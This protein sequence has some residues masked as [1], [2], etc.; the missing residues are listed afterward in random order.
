MEH[1]SSPFWGP[2]ITS[3]IISTISTPI[4]IKVAWYFGLIDNPRKHLHKKVVHTYPVPRGGGL[5]III[6]LV[7]SSL[8]WLPFDSHI[9]GII[10]GSLVAVSVGL[11]DD[12]WDISPYTRLATNVLSALCVIGVGIGIAFINN[13]LG[14]IIE[15]NGLQ[16]PIFLLGEWRSI[17]ILADAIAVLWIIFMMNVIGIGAGGIEGQLPGVVVIA[18]I[19]ISLLSLQFSSDIAQWPVIILSAITAGAYLGFLPWNFFPQKIMPG[20]SGKSLAGFLLATLAILSTA[21]VGTMLVVLGLP[22]IDALFAFSRR[23]LGGKS[24]FWGDRS[25]LHHRLLDSGMSKSNIVLLY[26]LITTLFGLIALNVNSQQKVF[27]FLT[28]VLIVG[29]LLVAVPEKRQSN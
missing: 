1:V 13:P 24:P 4:A 26:W 5:P 2:F 25:H 3:L 28:L 15:L 14:G 12:R 18:G 6:S 17:S 22:I 11:I 9:V 19:V 8:I 21:K 16:W 10:I 27:G 23:I 29:V 20:Y 7:L